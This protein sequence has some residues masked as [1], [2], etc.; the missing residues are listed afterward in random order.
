MTTDL[1]EMLPAQ[2]QEHILQQLRK[3]GRVMANDLA[4]DFGVSEDSV[5]RDLRDMAAKG[6]CRRVY[7]GA[8]LPTPEFSSLAERVAVKD[9]SRSAL[10]ARVASLIAPGQVALLDAGS[11]NV[12]IARFLRG[13]GVT[14]ITNSPSVAL[15]IADDSATEV[16]IIGG[17]LDLKSGGSIGAQALAQLSDIQVDV[18]IP[19][20]CAVDPNSGIW[21]VNAEE[22]AFKQV[23]M[24]SSG[25]TIIAAT[26]G[27][28]GTRGAYRIAALDQIDHLVITASAPSAMVKALQHSVAQLHIASLA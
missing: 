2:R 28:L 7:G 27:K 19:G 21:G 15:A 3:T 17:K 6:L 5:R 13:K 9:P 22:T 14:V 26:D 12:E 11:T 10:A 8:L 25:Q 20:A 1:T 16:V 24:R 23:M 18:C 4:Q